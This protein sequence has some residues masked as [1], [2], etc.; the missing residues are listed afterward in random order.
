M[1]GP[2]SSVPP[3]GVRG[4]SMEGAVGPPIVLCLPCPF[5][6]VRD[7]PLG[8]G[9]DLGVA[10]RAVWGAWAP[11]HLEPA[12]LFAVPDLVRPHRWCPIQFCDA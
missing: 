9:V 10:A 6:T 12:G 4:G 1:V 11:G 2:A 3:A 8:P 7:F 5:R